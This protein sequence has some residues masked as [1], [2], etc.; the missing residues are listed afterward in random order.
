MANIIM[1]IKGKEHLDAILDAVE[2]DLVDKGHL[3][4]EVAYT[5]NRRT[6]EERYITGGIRKNGTDR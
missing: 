4:T 1:E 6:G 3:L 2:K 5:R